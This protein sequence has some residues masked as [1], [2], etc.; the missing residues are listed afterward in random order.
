MIQDQVLI[1]SKEKVKE[2]GRLLFLTQ[3]GSKLYGTNVPTSDDDYVGVFLAKPEF[4]LGFKEVKEIDASIKYKDE[5]G[6]NTAEAIDIKL[7]ELKTFLKLAMDSNPNIVELL[8]SEGFFNTLEFLLFQNNWKWFINQRV[9]YSFLGYA[10]QQFKKGVMKAQNFKELKQFK[11]LLEVQINIDKGN[12]VLALLVEKS[13]FLQKHNKG[14]TVEFNG[15]HFQ[16]NLFIKKV[17]KMVNEKLKMSSHRASQWE[18]FGYDTKFFM[19]LLRLLEE[20][21]TLLNVEPLKFPL[22]NAD[23]LKEVRSGKFSLEELQELAEK[24][25]KEI[26]DMKTDLPKKANIKKI[27]SY[28]IN[29]VKNEIF[30]KK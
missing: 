26:E 4:Y 18:E 12:E 29:I 3:T 1:R 10:R 9:R 5:S 28:L 23:Y 11:E 25:F 6:K 20:G 8:F 22:Q 7:Y 21:K 16:K 19:H 14:K 15:L 13:P 17:L 2:F 24:G 27:E 30:L